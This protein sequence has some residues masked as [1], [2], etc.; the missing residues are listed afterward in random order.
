MNDVKHIIIAGGS[1]FI[2]QHLAS[3]LTEK[4][5]AVSL[6]GRKSSKTGPYNYYSWEP[7]QG[8]IDPE[9]LKGKDVIINLSG[10]G[11]ADRLWT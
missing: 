4:G 1:G 2:G 11:I 5:Y 8:K 10:A 9:A 7:T 6:L 3:H